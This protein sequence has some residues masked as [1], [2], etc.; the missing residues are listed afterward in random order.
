MKNQNFPVSPEE[1]QRQ[2]NL[3]LKGNLPTQVLRPASIGDGIIKLTDVDIK[4]Y[5]SVFNQEK[6]KYSIIKFVPASGAATRMFKEW[7][8]FHQDFVPGKDFYKRFIK[9]HQL[10]TFEE[11]AEDFLDNLAAYAFYEDLMEILLQNN[12]GFHQLDENEQVWQAIHYTLSDE[13]LGYQNNPKALILFHR[14]NKNYKKTA[15]EEHY[16]E[17]LN[18]TK[19]KNDVPELH[20]TI[21]PQHLNKFDNLKEKLSQNYEVNTGFSFQKPSTDTIMLNINFN[22]VK[23]E[24]GNF[25]FRPGGHGALIENIQD[26][27]ADIIFIKNID[28]VQKGEKK[29]DT[30]L[31]KKVLGGILIEKLKKIHQYLRQLN[32]EKPAGE[33]LKTIENFARNEMNIRMIEGFDQL[34]NSGKRRYLF[35][36][37]NRPVRIAGV[38]KNTGEPGGGPFWA[39][40]KNGIESLQIVEKAQIDFSDTKQK[41]AFE[42]STHFNPVDLVISIKD[43]EGKKFDLQEFINKK[44]GF[45]TE[46]SFQGQPVKVYERPG[47]WNG[48]MDA[49]NT[50]FVEVPLTTFSP[51]KIV[52]DLLK[53]PHQ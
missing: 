46:K 5:L 33:A 49:W 51:V 44:A 52:N 7:T 39:Y 31:F 48:A 11:E 22:P 32:L 20:F 43:F 45:I 41:E 3:I 47:L 50:I 17:A 6:E 25:I 23:D 12:S 2:I 10:N 24:K 19:G 40:D 35:Y 8:F 18:Y 21:S 30:L 1:I 29:S 4:K 34:D 26:L 38:V 13:G 28:N 14:Y 9:K 36:K 42:Q 16:V 15:M 27:D 37:L 53:P